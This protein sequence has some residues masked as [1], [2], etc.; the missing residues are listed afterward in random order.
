MPQEHGR[1]T[2]LPGSK[3]IAH[4]SGKASSGPPAWKPESSQ[5]WWLSTQAASVKLANSQSMPWI[6]LH[7]P[8]ACPH[9]ARV[10]PDKKHK[11][12]RRKGL[13]V[14]E[15]QNGV[16]ILSLHYFQ[17]YKEVMSGNFERAHSAPSNLEFAVLQTLTLLHK[18]KCRAFKS[19]VWFLISSKKDSMYTRYRLCSNA[20]KVP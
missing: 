10:P 4:S 5:L 17:K 9:Q 18:L 12:K 14:R 1:S 8:P 7:R 11:R 2:K 6:H 15:L 13:A 16:E 19:C 20:A 3:Q